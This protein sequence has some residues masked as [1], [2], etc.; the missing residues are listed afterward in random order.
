VGGGAAS[1]D[2][3]CQF[4]SDILGIPVIRPRV[5]EATALGATFAAGIAVGTWED[6]DAVSQLWEEDR[7][8]EPRLAGAERL[9]LLSQWSRAVERSRNWDQEEAS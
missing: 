9:Q 2:F 6:T 1:N 3:L 7:R 5:L 4:Q 8:F